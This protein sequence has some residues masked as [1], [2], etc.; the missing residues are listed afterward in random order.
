MW[1]DK[2][3]IFTQARLYVFIYYCTFSKSDWMMREK[4]KGGGVKRR[5]RGEGGSQKTRKT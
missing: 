2:K 4:E 1:R 3:G 5:K